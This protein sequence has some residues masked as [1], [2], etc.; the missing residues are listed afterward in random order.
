M[1]E[2]NSKQLANLSLILASSGFLATMPFHGKLIQILSGGF[3]AALVGGLADWFAVTAM[4]RHPLNIPIPHTALLP[5]NRDKITESILNTLNEQWL[6]KESLMQKVEKGKW[7]E[8]GIASFEQMMEQKETKEKIIQTVQE[9]VENIP[10]ESIDTLIRKALQQTTESFHSEMLLDTVITTI[11]ENE[12][13][14][15]TYEFLIE[16]IEEYLHSPSIKE[17]IGRTAIQMIEKK[18]PMVK[19][20]IPMIGED[21][22]ASLVHS[23][24]IDLL[25]Y[26]KDPDNENRKAILSFV[27]KE[28]EKSKTNEKLIGKLE[29]WKQKGL[30]YV[31]TQ[32]TKWIKQKITDDHFIIETIHQ[33]TNFFKQPHWME[34]GERSVKQLFNHIID[35]YHNKIGGLVRHNIEKLSTEEITVLLEEK[36]GNDITWIRINGATCGFLIG[37]ALTSIRMYFA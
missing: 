35:K 29:E 18:I 25:S 37:L 13:D 27:Q 20:F 9:I 6:S 4:F 19:A 10:N 3:E 26:L 12:W 1:S 8:T 30:D 28:I 11:F 32:G 2:K 34:K 21:T 16:K 33:G 7:I 15:K 5:K 31:V 23:G 24:A 17:Q 22:I 36:I 14:E